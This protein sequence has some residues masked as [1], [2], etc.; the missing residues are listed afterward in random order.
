M[1]NVFKN[2]KIKYLI[3]IVIIIC[4]VLYYKYYEKNNDSQIVSEQ[5]NF[6]KDNISKS[7]ESLSDT[8]ENIIQENVKIVVYVAGEVVNPGVYEMQRND[9][10]ADVIERAGG[11]KSEADI[12][13]I[14]LAFALEDGMKVYIPNI[15]EKDVNSI[16]LNGEF[17]ANN[18][19]SSDSSKN[20]KMSNNSKVNINV[21]T[22]EQLELLPGIGSSTANKIVNYRNE[23]GKFKCIEDI[24][25][26]SGI[27]DSKFTKIKDLITIK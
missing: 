4:A 13:N 23:H 21:A 7:N 16:I 12:K 8:N 11:L 18:S 15:N 17:E 24:K 25:N 14:N 6:T 1:K 22:Q 19:I 9:R 10:I 20:T 3:I 5:L 27:G 26:V 2:N